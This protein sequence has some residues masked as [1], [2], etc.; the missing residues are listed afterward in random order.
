MAEV[1]P[2]F[3]LGV[4]WYGKEA[5]MGTCTGW[6]PKG[7]RGDTPLGGCPQWLIDWYSSATVNES[8]T[9]FTKLSYH[10]SGSRPTSRHVPSVFW[11]AGSSSFP[12]AVVKVRLSNTYLT[13]YIVFSFFQIIK[14]LNNGL[15]EDGTNLEMANNMRDDSLKLWRTRMHRVM[16]SITNCAVSMKVRP[17]N[18]IIFCYIP[19]PCAPWI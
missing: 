12:I 6:F 13:C 9:S 11:V 14:N 3:L 1:S 4:T 10:K 19:L 7:W 15:S 17:T 18:T 16:Y 2:C 5:C 8:A